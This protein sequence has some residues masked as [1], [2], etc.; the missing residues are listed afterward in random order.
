M[1]RIAMIGGGPK[2]LFA[3]LALNDG[4]EEY[5]DLEV[6]VDVYDPYPPGAGRVW[7]TKQPQ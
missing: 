6:R 1:T 3:L 7:N 4:L 5:P 2:C